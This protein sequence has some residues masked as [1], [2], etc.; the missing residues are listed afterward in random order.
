M[1]KGYGRVE[2]GILAA[3]RIEPDN[4]FTTDSETVEKKHRVA[5]L[6]AGYSLMRRPE[7]SWLRVRHRSWGSDKMFLFF[8]S[9]NLQSYGMARAK[10]PCRSEAEA[11]EM[12]L[13]DNQY[14]YGYAKHMR[15]GGLFWTHVQKFI[16]EA[17]EA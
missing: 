2:L 3:F 14:G 11:R 7:F 1:S 9:C 16:A 12:L 5:I 15:E 13:E 4:A 8:D 6:R 17:A 10:S